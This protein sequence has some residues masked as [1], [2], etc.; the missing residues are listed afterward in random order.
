MRN[1]V[2]FSA[3]IAICVVCGLVGC[4]KNPVDPYELLSGTVISEDSLPLRGIHIS[5][6]LD[7]EL[8]D[9]VDDAITDEKGYYVSKDA[10]RYVEGEKMDTILIYVVADD[11]RKVYE[12]DTIET[13]LIYT[14]SQSRGS[15]KADFVLKK[16]EQ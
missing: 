13:Q 4:D 10:Y 12:S 7:K 8:E 2:I 6:Y 15:A 9:F 14:P 1:R 3:L 16:K 11:P 5:K